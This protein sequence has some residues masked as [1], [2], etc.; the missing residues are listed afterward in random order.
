MAGVYVNE[1][2]EST[3]PGLYAAGD[4]AAVP[5]QHLTGAFVF[6]EV[7]AEQAVEFIQSRKKVGLDSDQIRA[8]EERRNQYADRS[9]KEIKIG[10][11][12]YKVRRI[13]GDYVVSPKNEYKLKRWMESSKV[14]KKELAQMAM[15]RNHHELTRIFE[16]ENIIKC[17]DISATAALAR[18]ESRWGDSHR[19]CDYPGKDDANWLKHVIVCIDPDNS[20]VHVSYRPIIDKLK[21]EE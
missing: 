6:G 5:K 14:F 7:A 11:M 10:E 9:G 20:N 17:A 3:V 21:E 8:V 1:R 12:E 13:I 4:V 2:A 19:R 18:K 16:L 15:A